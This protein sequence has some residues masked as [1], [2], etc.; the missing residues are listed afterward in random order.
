HPR[1]GDG[2]AVGVEAQG[3]RQ[4]DVLLP[5]AVAVAGDAGVRAVVDRPRPGAEDVPDRRRTAVRLGGALDLEGRAARAPGEA[6]V[7]AHVPSSRA[8]RP[9]ARLRPRGA[10]TSR[11]GAR[12][13]PPARGSTRRASRP[14]GRSSPPASR[15]A[16]WPRTP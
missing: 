9:E 4:V 8:G 5:A 10:G 7:V 14:A 11:R 2:E 15:G 13:A 12:R 3:R 6:H 16:T 1:P